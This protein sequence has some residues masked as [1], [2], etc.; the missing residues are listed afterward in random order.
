MSAQE[1]RG[2]IVELGYQYQEFAAL[3]GFSHN[4]VYQW[5]NELRPIPLVVERLLECGMWP[6]GRPRFAPL[7]TS[8][9]VEWRQAEARGRARGT[10]ND[11]NRAARAEVMLR[12]RQPGRKLQ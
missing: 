10:T 11:E 1:L 12:N 8:A 9:G 7:D 5:I 3:I 6:L 2:M 4:S